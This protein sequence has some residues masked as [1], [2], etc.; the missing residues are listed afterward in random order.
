MQG[1]SAFRGQGKSRDIP[2]TRGWYI[3]VVLVLAGLSIACN[4]TAIA[5]AV[6]S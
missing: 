6:L 4:L 5:I 3:G 2:E 1:I